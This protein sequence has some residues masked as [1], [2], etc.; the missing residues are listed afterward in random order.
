MEKTKEAAQL[1]NNIKFLSTMKTMGERFKKFSLSIR[2]NSEDIRDNSR[3]KKLDTFEK[4]QVIKYLEFHWNESYPKYNNSKY[5]IYL[6][7]L[8]I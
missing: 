4:D 5:I 8:Q 7:F 1:I 3:G 2:E 6:K